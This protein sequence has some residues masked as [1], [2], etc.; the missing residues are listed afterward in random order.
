MSRPAPFSRR[1]LVLG[2]PAVLAGGLLAA[3]GSDP[4]PPGAP[5]TGEMDPEEPA[6][7]AT[8]ELLETLVTEIHEAVVAADEDRDDELL[9]PRVT[10]SAAQFRS[11]AY[12][13]IAEAEEWEEELN[14]PGDELMV[15]LTSIGR[16]FPRWAI[17]L[18]EDSSDDGV[19]YFMAL[20]QEDARSPYTSWGWAQQ[21]VDIEMPMVPHQETGAEPVDF[22][23]SEL[24]M[25]PSEALELYAKV[26]SDGVDADSDDQLASDPFQS[27]THENIQAEREDLN[28]GVD[29]DEAAT[30]KEVFTVSDDEFIGLRTDDGGA[31]VMGTLLSTRTVSIKDD[32]T[33]RYG[34]ENPYTKVI[35]ER[36]FTEE[37]VREFGTHVALFIPASGSDLQ[38]QPIGATQTAL[39]VSG[40]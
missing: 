23:D 40:Q 34:E 15:P 22:D 5:P 9:S 31:I 24:L 35:G 26:L 33:M 7:V 2:A 4:E 37:F 38:V 28:S 30:I 8:T 32:A 39:D 17:A 25:P 27:R 36:E 21:A 1:K 20:E 3:C 10:G 16:D 14:V 13:M 12:A 6:P 29:W 18:V 11:A 19:P